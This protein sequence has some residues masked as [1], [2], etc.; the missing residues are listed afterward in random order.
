MKYG[1]I[2]TSLSEYF[3]IW[4]GK[5]PVPA[6]DVIFSL[7]KARSLMAGVSLGIFEV[8]KDVPLTPQEIAARCQLDAECTEI[9]L[10][11]LVSIEYL[12]QSGNK[13]SLSDLSRRTLVVGAKDDLSGYIQW[14]YTQWEMIGHLEELI[15]T[16]KGIDFHQTMDAPEKWANY[17]QAML[18][19]AR[20]QAPV[21]ASKVPVK[22]GARRLLD[23]AGSHGLIGATICR[24]HPPMKS[25]VVDL[26]EAIEHARTLAHLE[27]IDDIVTH[28]A[29]DILSD[30][31]G[32]DYDVVLAANI[33]H[34]FDEGA[35]LKI[36]RRVHSSL[37]S[38]GTVAIWEIEAPDKTAKA[39]E[40]DGAVLFFRLTSNA[41]CYSGG[42]YTNWLKETGFEEI[43]VKRPLLAPGFVL[44]TARREK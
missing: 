12:E 35:N 44:V 37:N 43:K 32:D 26:P 29:G 42:D 40:T 34:H 17:Q 36:L 13:Y 11:T 33:L 5:M 8:L 21:M 15:R 39:N 25:E 20:F 23:L 27:Q 28:Q 1:L 6:I 9:L 16:G 19:V 7:I 14:N 18:E 10:R 2:P 3:A 22:P 4:A 41:R 31:Y 24:L 38:N 30:S